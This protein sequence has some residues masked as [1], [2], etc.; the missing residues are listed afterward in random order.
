M[1]RLLALLTLLA[2]ASF[3]FAASASAEAKKPSLKGLFA[4]HGN[5]AFIQTKPGKLV[6]R[7]LRTGAIQR[8]KLPSNAGID[9]SL[10]RVNSHAVA[11]VN[12]WGESKLVLQVNGIGMKPRVLETVDLNSACALDNDLRVL[13]IDSTDTVTA[14]RRVGTPTPN[15]ASCTVAPEQT[16]ITKYFRNG[17][18]VDVPIPVSYRTNISG[19][20]SSLALR[21][22]HLL[23]PASNESESTPSVVD[24]S[25][26]E[27]IWEG[28]RPRAYG[29]SLSAPGVIWASRDYLGRSSRV[30]LFNY[31]TRKST[32]IQIPHP[33]A[34][35]PCGE[36]SLFASGHALEIYNG[37]GRLVKK[38]R[39][40]WSD[41][42]G[43]GEN[44]CSGNFA[45]VPHLKGAPELI[46]LSR[47]R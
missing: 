21:G 9:D 5:S 35:Q 16:V 47:L 29:W 28:P 22:N 39:A 26:G 25:T 40:R 3:A 11:S 46:D 33:R 30:Y 36:F 42:Y 4:I 12:G 20:A 18:V 24:L 43:G 38:A 19:L 14:I 31:I 44:I 13:Q 2:F 23:V 45:F 27:V 17:S 7:N 6:V 8:A 32:T 41:P 1:K 34:G 37:K 10:I 15:G